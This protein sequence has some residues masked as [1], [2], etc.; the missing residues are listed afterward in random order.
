MKN[1]NRKLVKGVVNDYLN[2]KKQTQTNKINWL[3]RPM[4]KNE[5]NIIFFTTGVGWVIFMGWLFSL[6]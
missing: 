5:I 3:Y 2:N 1:I 4:T 6:M